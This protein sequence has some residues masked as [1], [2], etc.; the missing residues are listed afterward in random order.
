[1]FEVLV[2]RNAEIKKST[3]KNPNAGRNA[4]QEIIVEI[5]DMEDWSRRDDIDNSVKYTGTF[6]PATIVSEEVLQR[7]LEKNVKS[8]DNL[9][10][11]DVY[12]FIV[13]EAKEKKTKNG[14]P[15]LLLS[16]VGPTGQG[17]NI[18]CWGWDGVRTIAPYTACIAQ[19]NADSFGCKTFM[20]KLKE[21]A[22]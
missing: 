11:D 20:S 6:N 4:M 14:K 16:T 2:N 5:S 8:I 7:L 19:V 21:L 10:G 17:R 13:T 22:V 9:D 18:F 1:M 12:W 3:K 15:Y